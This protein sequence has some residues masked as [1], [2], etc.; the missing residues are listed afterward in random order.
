[1]KKLKL[2]FAMACLG[3]LVTG[4]QDENPDQSGESGLLDFRTSNPV[5]IAGKSM[6]YLKSVAEN[7]PLTGD[8]TKT[9]T[10][11]L[12]LC[13]GDVW[14]SQGEVKEGEADSLEWLRITGSTNREIKLFEDYSFEAKTIPV[15]TYNSIKITFR[16]VFYRYAQLVS[17][18]SITYE[19][20]ET[21]GSWTEPC[22][23]NDTTWATTNYFGPAGNHR[24][25]DDDVFE[26]VSDGEKIGGFTIEADKTAIVTW[27]LGAGVTTPCITYLIDENDNLVWD[28]GID[29]M[30]FECP[31]E[32]EYMWDFVVDYE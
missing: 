19:L 24:L 32:M 1:M 8:T 6:S 2:I 10:T 12:L 4:C 16:N 17:D 27:R 29:R 21:M 7:P 26:L 14:V 25:N 28:C 13:I 11:S 3:L 15:G 20:L 31:P 30:E 18:P 22:D 23:V 5:V 9:Y